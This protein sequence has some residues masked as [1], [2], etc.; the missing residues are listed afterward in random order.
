M[1]AMA[2]MWRADPRAFEPLVAPLQAEDWKL[3][4]CACRGLAHLG[5]P[6]AAPPMLPLFK[7]P[8]WR[9]RHTACEALL[10]LEVSDRRV[11]EALRRLAT[12]PESEEYDLRAAESVRDL[13]MM[14]EMTEEGDPE[15]QP[16]PTM[17]ELIQQ[18]ESLLATAER[19]QP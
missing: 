18:A 14:R 15:P 13:P 3:V 11:V 7:H 8:Q 5:D 19:P 17:A 16:L 1:R 12:E 9:I 2:F 4:T 6:R 10:D